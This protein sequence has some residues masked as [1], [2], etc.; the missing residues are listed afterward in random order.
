LVYCKC[1]QK[2]GILSG[3]P[4]VDPNQPMDP[5]EHGRKKSFNL[6]FF[7]K[8]CYSSDSLDGGD[9]TTKEEQAPGKANSADS[10][11][12]LTREENNITKEADDEDKTAQYAQQLERYHHQAKTARYMVLMLI[13]IVWI[14]SGLLIGLG[15]KAL[16]EVI[17]SAQED[18][19]VVLSLTERAENATSRYALQA[20]QALRNRVELIESF[21][22]CDF[23][24]SVLQSLP[25][26]IQIARNIS[27]EGNI[28]EILLNANSTL[29]NTTVF[30]NIVNS[31][32]ESLGNT[33]KLLRT[34][35]NALSTVSAMI[36]TYKVFATLIF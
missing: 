27:F 26:E 35:E 6:P 31:I 32:D 18:L 36:A 30:G 11:N 28:T 13:P 12:V 17:Q 21:L 14:W 16:Q 1:T 24:S 3:S 25:F 20:D 22:E 9:G 8:S 5:S 34:A 19:P 4:P 23:D 29:E 33:T 7:W 15:F 10:D 2:G